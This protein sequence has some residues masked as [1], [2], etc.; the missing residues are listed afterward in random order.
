MIA[1]VA[2]DRQTLCMTGRPSH[3]TGGPS[4]DLKAHDMSNPCI[5]IILMWLTWNYVINMYLC[6]M[7]IDHIKLV[8][9]FSVAPGN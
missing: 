3:M 5:S 4:H 1:V 2:H 8:T 6:N 9:Q 7:N